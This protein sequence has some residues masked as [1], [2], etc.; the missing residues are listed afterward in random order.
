MMF[1]LLGLLT[2]GT[3]GA[4]MLCLLRIPKEGESPLFNLEGMSRPLL[5]G[6]TC[7]LYEATGINEGLEEDGLLFWGVPDK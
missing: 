6:E 1:L 3:W 2:M 4:P 7:Q 5:V